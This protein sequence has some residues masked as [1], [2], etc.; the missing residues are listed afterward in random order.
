MTGPAGL[1]AIK[2]PCRIV[3]DHRFYKHPTKLREL[4]AEALLNAKP[5][6]AQQ[7]PKHVEAVLALAKLQQQAID[8]I[9]QHMPDQQCRDEAA[10]KKTKSP[11]SK[12]T[13][14][15]DDT[16]RSDIDGY[17]SNASRSA[18][19]RSRSYIYALSTALAPGP[20]GSPRPSL[21]V[22]G[23]SRVYTDRNTPPPGL[24]SG[25]NSSKPNRFHISASRHLST[26]LT[27]KPAVLDNAKETVKTL[28]CL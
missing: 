18:S 4:L 27:P 25:T 8:D 5:I 11:S 28:E 15:G 16:T 13:E 9:E 21:P 23:K 20:H 12:P 2:T 22:R 3:R 6:G 14:H 24:E 1:N 17:Q 7:Q 19:K 10:I 26:K